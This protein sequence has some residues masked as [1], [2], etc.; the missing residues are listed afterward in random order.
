M[1]KLTYSWQILIKSITFFNLQMM[2]Y[3]IFFQNLMSGTPW[4]INLHNE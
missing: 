1:E 2:N 4:I 3:M